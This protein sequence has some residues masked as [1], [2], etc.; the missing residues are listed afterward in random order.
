MKSMAY[1]PLEYHLLS[2]TISYPKL[3]NFLVT[4]R[5]NLRCEICHTADVLTKTKKGELNFDEV[6]CLIDQTIKYKP[7]WFFSGGE[8]FARL[9]LPE[10]LAYIQSLG[11]QSSLVSNGLLI[12]EKLLKRIKKESLKSITISV[13]G[14]REGH[15]EEVC[16]VG[17]Y[18]SLKSNL[19]L[20]HRYHP[21]TSIYI[22]SPL[23]PNLIKGLPD[24][25]MDFKDLPIQGIKFTHLNYLTMKEIKAY[26]TYCEKHEFEHSKA[27]SYV[28]DD[29]YSVLLKQLKDAP[30]NNLPFPVQFAPQLSHQEINNWYNQEFK[31]SRPCH[32]IWHSTYIYPNGDV[33]SC[34]FLQET[35]GNIRDESLTKIWNNDKYN[36]FRR[37]I[38]KDISP[39]CARC[40][41]L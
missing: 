15:D 30:F 26:R 28:S 13:F 2:K 27:H 21:K 12:N 1:F 40:C 22:N 29:D 4:L 10:I 41:K 23:T 37:T 31:S 32:F 6:R 18:E 36:R 9:D 17:A 33:K 8:P 16:K 11:M 5:C 39:A 35:F 25:A 19:K 38:K 34:H 7:D 14:V 20:L 3:I 24:L